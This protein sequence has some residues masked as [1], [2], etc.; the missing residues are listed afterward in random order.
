ML[1]S[2]S[3]L[4]NV[5]FFNESKMALICLAQ[6]CSTSAFL[7]LEGVIL[8]S[9]NPNSLTMAKEPSKVTFIF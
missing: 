6:I 9:K 5:T 1:F 2:Q 8:T 3:G 4:K 7:I